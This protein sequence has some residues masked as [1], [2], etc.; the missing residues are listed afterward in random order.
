KK[1]GELI[2]VTIAGSDIDY[3]GNSFRLILVNDITKQ[4]EAEAMVLSSLVEGEN[5]ERARIAR[6]LHDG[7]GQYLA[8]ANMNFDAVQ[9]DLQ[10]LDERRQKQFKKGLT[11]LKHAVTETAQI[12]R[13]LLPRVVHDY[14]LALA[15]EALIDNYSSNTDIEITYY[16]N[17]DGVKLPRK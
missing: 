7:L 12:S 6:E 11:L 16:H 4:K 8:A 2:Y 1:N 15:I 5:K 13:N 14:G 17:I 3:F 10:K 9:N